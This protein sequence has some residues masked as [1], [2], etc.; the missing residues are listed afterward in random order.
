MNK[1]EYIDLTPT[2]EWTVSFLL[3]LI[4]DGNQKKAEKGFQEEVERLG[5]DMKE[6]IK[7]FRSSKGKAREKSREFL[8]DKARRVDAAIAA[9]KAKK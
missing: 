2:W 5:P 8:I 4:E 1:T 3:R 7:D 9:K 6:L